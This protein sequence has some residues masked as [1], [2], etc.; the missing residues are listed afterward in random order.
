MQNLASDRFGATSSWPARPSCTSAVQVHVLTEQEIMVERGRSHRDAVT[1]DEVPDELFGIQ[2]VAEPCVDQ[3]QSLFEK[4]KTA[5]NRRLV[6]QRL[7]C[8]GDI[9]VDYARRGL[10]LNRFA[11]LA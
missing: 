2:V 11:G 1:Q 7:K 8:G 6:A 9:R 10:D 4:V 5:P 3:T